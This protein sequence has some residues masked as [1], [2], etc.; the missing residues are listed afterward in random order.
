MWG[1]QNGLVGTRFLYLGLVKTTNKGYWRNVGCFR[2]FCVPFGTV[3]P[4]FFREG[5]VFGFEIINF[6]LHATSFFFSVRWVWE[7]LLSR[8]NT[9]LCT[10]NVCMNFGYGGNDIA[11]A[12]QIR[13][14]LLVLKPSTLP[15]PV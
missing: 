4:A 15:G 3:L 14:T 6:F 9:C 13:Q 7:Q 8:S 5:N 12:G 11:W 10:W 1:T 2:V